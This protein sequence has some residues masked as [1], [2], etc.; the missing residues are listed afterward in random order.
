MDKTKL[1]KNEP[2]VLLVDGQCLLCNRIT[3]FVAR[4]DKARVFQFAM[5]QSLVGQQLLVEGNFPLEEID[6]FVMVQGE[7]HY[8][9]SDAALRVFRKLD[10]W[11]RILYLFIV[12]P[13]AWRNWVYDII[14]RNRYRIFGRADVCLLPTPE[15]MGRFM[16]HG[17][18]AAS[19][20]EITGE[21]ETDPGGIRPLRDEIRE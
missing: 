2:A 8:T 18:Q 21:N 17:A 15:L 19:T 14:A 16:E 20:G 7:R 3:H 13:L 10:G 4:R 12:V 11:W 9:K 6:T 5:L 1:K